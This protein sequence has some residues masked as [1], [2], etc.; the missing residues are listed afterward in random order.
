MPNNLLTL[1]IQARMNSTRFPN[2][3]L[4]DLS[5]TPLIERILQRVKKV[6]RIG[7]IIIATTKR[8]EDDM[9]IKL[10][11]SYKSRGLKL[12]YPLK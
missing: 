5:G 12:D 3:V 1:V 11:R 4:S 2:K 10:Q 9:V 6:K 7:K 8:K